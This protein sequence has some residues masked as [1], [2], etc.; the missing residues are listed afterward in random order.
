MNENIDLTK[1][2]ANAPK[3]LELYTPICG[4]VTFGKA[5]KDSKE[6]NFP[7]ECYSLN[8][9]IGDI[10]ISFSKDGRFYEGGECL[11]FPSKDQRDWSK[12]DI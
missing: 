3:G 12:F 6:D 4:T 8:G 9:D 2:L 7:I 10:P 11:L 5:E 1:I